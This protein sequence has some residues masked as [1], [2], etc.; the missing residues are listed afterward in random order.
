[1][2]TRWPG[3]FCAS[4]ATER[5][6]GSMNRRIVRIATALL[7][8]TFASGC[9]A[10]GTGPSTGHVAEYNRAP[11]SNVVADDQYVV[12]LASDSS[13]VAAEAGQLVSQSGGELLILYEGAVRGFAARIPDRGFDRLRSDPRVVRIYQDLWLAFSSAG[14]GTQQ[15][16]KNGDPWGLDRIDQAAHPLNREYVYSSTGSGVTVYVVDSGIDA[17]HPDFGGRADESAA[18]ALSNRVRPRRAWTRNRR[19][20]HRCWSNLW[21]SQGR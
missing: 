3:L 7:W 20:Q 10:L 8:I 14:G 2:T 4:A 5:E 6:T 13:D 9:D 12:I 15:M 16:D 11:A 17:S 18:H 21:C 19:R 1:M